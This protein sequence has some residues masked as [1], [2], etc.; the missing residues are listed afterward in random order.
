M[1]PAMR[2]KISLTQVPF[3]PYCC[4]PER[5]FHQ[6]ADSE[7]GPRH[8]VRQGLAV[9]LVEQRLVV[10]RVDLRQ[11]AVEKQKNHVLGARREMGLLHRP[12]IA[13]QG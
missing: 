12:G 2:G 13:G 1:I 5:R 7:L 8:L 4:E 9:V 6:V 11:A 10:K 3:A